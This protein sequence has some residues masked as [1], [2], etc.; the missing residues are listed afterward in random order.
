MTTTFEKVTQTPGTTPLK[1]KDVVNVTQKPK[2]A[3]EF[4][5][6]SSGE[7]RD[8]V[9]DK[10]DEDS[11]ATVQGTIPE[12]KD[13]IFSFDGAPS[14]LT[15]HYRSLRK[16][17]AP[18]KA[19]EFDSSVLQIA[20]SWADKAY[21]GPGMFMCISDCDDYMM[22]F[23]EHERKVNVKGDDIEGRRGGPALEKT[24]Q[25]EFAAQM[26]LQLSE[27]YEHIHD[28]HSEFNSILESNIWIMDILLKFSADSFQKSFFEWEA[29]RYDVESM[30]A[31]FLSCLY[32]QYA[33]GS[34]DGNCKECS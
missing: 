18:W 13:E 19:Y 26:V 9:A 5:V 21:V 25:V 11:S 14:D 17:E 1:L 34:V 2:L 30:G 24:H 3:A 15:N 12:V 28:F 27:S 31:Q 10:T 8:Q 6:N 33:P 16:R 23:D 22:T 29:V 32:H 4:S 7:I 20:D